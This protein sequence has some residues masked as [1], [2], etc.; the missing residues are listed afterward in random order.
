M[1]WVNIIV[2]GMSR[3]QKIK[4]AKKFVERY[5]LRVYRTPEYLVDSFGDDVYGFAFDDSPC[6]DRALTYCICSPESDEIIVSC[7]V[8]NN[9]GRM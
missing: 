5:N 4:A 9:L 2:D 3:E 8:C 6:S 1:T 7:G